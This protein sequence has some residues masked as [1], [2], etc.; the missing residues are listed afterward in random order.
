MALPILTLPP[1][2]YIRSYRR[3][4]YQGLQLQLLNQGI[5]W[6]WIEQVLTLRC[7]MLGYTTRCGLAR[8]GVSPVSANPPAARLE[9]ANLLAAWTG[10]CCYCL[11]TNF[12]PLP[13][14]ELTGA[15]WARTFCRCLDTNLLL[16]P[17]HEPSA[18]AWT[19]TYCCC[20]GMNLLPLPGH[21]LTAAVWA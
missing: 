1:L 19:R 16:L 11:G 13:G 21:E 6:A 8:V 5:G 7:T 18:A 12:Q 17:G 2:K 10:I 14:L 20:L 9:P 3:Y 4:Y 15:A